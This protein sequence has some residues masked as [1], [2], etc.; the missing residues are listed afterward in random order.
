MED[1]FEEQ[2]FSAVL[3]SD[4]DEAKSTSSDSTS[5]PSTA[6]EIKSADIKLQ[7]MRRVARKKRGEGNKLAV[8]A[9]F[10]LH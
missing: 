5:G 1:S 10:F 6:L 7:Q 9:R 8:S 4:D 2:P 3:E